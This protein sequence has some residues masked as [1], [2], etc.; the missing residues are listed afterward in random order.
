MFSAGDETS[1]VD[2]SGFVDSDD[3]VFYVNAFTVGC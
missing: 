2:G 3:F 1:D